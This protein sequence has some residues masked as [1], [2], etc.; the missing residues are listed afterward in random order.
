M[1]QFLLSGVVLGGTSCVQA[2]A[3]DHVDFLGSLQP[4]VAAWSLVV[5][6][7]NGKK[8]FPPP[9]RAI[10]QDKLASMLRELSRSS[11]LTL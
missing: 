1:V 2:S 5:I 6:E 8:R 10:L 4:D 11:A 9:S 7:R 3:R